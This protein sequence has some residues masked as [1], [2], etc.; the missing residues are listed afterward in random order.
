LFLDFG[1]FGLREKNVCEEKKHVKILSPPSEIRVLRFL[2]LCQL[3]CSRFLNLGQVNC[4]C[5]TNLSLYTLHAVLRKLAILGQYVQR[6]KIFH[7]VLSSY[8]MCKEK[9]CILNNGEYFSLDPSLEF[10]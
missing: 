1:L 8:L 3:I 6:Q 2:N 4:L 7:G 9:K 5:T 10:V